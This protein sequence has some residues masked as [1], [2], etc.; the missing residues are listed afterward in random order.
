MAL[1]E[2]G[3]ILTAKDNFTD[4]INKAGR[5]ISNFKERS[6]KAMVMVGGAIAGAGIIVGKFGADSIK[7]FMEFEKEMLN[8]KAITGATESDFKNLSDMAKKMGAETAFTASE[9]AQA[10]KFMATAGFNAN[11]S[12]ASLPALLQLASAG[13]TDLAAT[14]DI[15]TDNI[16]AFG[17]M[18]KDTNV[19]AKNT[20]IFADV[21]AKASSS[22]NVDILTLGE[23][24]KYAAASATAMGYD[25][26]NTTALISVLGDSGLKG[27]TAGTTLNSMFND[28]SNKAK[29][30]S[31]SVNKT[32][33]SIQDSAGNFRKMQDILSDVNK[34]TS[35]LTDVQKKQ[36][37]SSIFGVE[38]MKGVNIVMAKGK[39]A[40]DEFENSLNNSAGTAQK[41]ANTQLGG[42]SG[43]MTLFDST[44]DSILLSVGEQLA[45]SLQSLAES[46]I[47]N[48]E[49]IIAFAS[50]MGDLAIL[51]MTT[52]TESFGIITNLIT[53]LSP[54]LAGLTAGFL[55]YKA[56]VIATN[57]YTLGFAATMQTLGIVTTFMDLKQKL[58][59]GGLKTTGVMTSL[60]TAKQWALNIALNAN[61]IGL[62]VGAV[63]ALVAGGILLYKNFDKIKESAMAL[64]EGLTKVWNSLTKIFTKTNNSK[65]DI[66]VNTTEEDGKPVDGTHKNGLSNVPKDGYIAELHKGER[67][68]TA[69]EN[70]GF[71]G[72]NITLGNINISSNSNDPKKIADEVISQIVNNLIPRLQNSRG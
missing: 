17:M 28:M 54:V 51:L 2:F 12:I 50:T 39:T 27:S 33:I 67:V 70:K 53:T 11:Q 38:A 35:K 69:N 44:V 63:A 56:V 23:S 45:P 65:L 64:W 59:N 46:F 62:I 18:S 42:L 57:L 32:N 25:L 30:G 13:A 37:L 52:V 48:K 1:K 7:K 10:L 14:A 3:A 9:S 36:A 24:F 72:G 16:S 66:K 31:I 26:Q 21:V 43:A 60:L 55:F 47:R 61:P 19:L 68:L 4:T 29:K 8:V 34:A 58:F 6:D 22:A 41:M 20:Q 71:L 49:P 5:S 15:V 40:V